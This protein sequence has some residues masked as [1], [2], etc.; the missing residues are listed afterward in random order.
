MSGYTKEPKSDSP[1]P[2]A[3][4][5]QVLDAPVKVDPTV[6]PT[7]Y[8]IH[9]SRAS[10][11]LR[12]LEAL[13][14][15]TREMEISIGKEKSKN[16]KQQQLLREA[17]QRVF[18]LT[19]NVEKLKSQLLA[20][21]AKEDSFSDQLR[22]QGQEISQL[23]SDLED[24]LQKRAEEKRKYALD[25]ESLKIL[26]QK[27]KQKYIDLQNEIDL[28]RRESERQIDFNTNL[29][30]FNNS[31]VEKKLQSELNNQVA[32]TRN[33]ENTIGQLR[34]DLKRS[35]DEADRE[36]EKLLQTSLELRKALAQAR[37]GE[38]ELQRYKLELM[39]A[40]EKLK[41]SEASILKAKQEAQEALE[42]ERRRGH[43]QNQQEASEV[44]SADLKSGKSSSGSQKNS[45][46]P[47][48]EFLAIKEKQIDAIH[49]QVDQGRLKQPERKKVDELLSIMVEQR[50]QLKEIVGRIEEH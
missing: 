15:S 35:K 22:K 6:L 26:I 1:I 7:D 45:S 18:E 20:Q 16:Y 14:R 43:A 38:G 13:C 32:I 39:R 37:T 3:S 33:L 24:V 10:G 42:R 11:F 19:G 9:G 36:K 28:L 30:Q 34:D 47:L 21:Q 49:K 46:E 8:S 4:E 31:I 23:R 40:R 25:C 48:K 17:H 44:V 5:K 12:E 50:D 41:A 29:Q 27:E 2:I